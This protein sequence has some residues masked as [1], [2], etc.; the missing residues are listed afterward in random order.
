[1]PS[2]MLADIKE[3]LRPESAP[4]R[5]IPSLDGGLTPNDALE[6]FASVVSL[7]DSEDVVADSGTAVLVTA[8]RALWRVDVRSGSLE[9][10]ASFTGKAMGLARRGDDVLVCVAGLGLVK[11]TGSGEVVPVATAP[12]TPSHRNLTSVTTLGEDIYVTRGS[13]EHTAE[14]WPRDLMT[15]GATGAL[16]RVEPGGGLTTVADGIAWAYGACALED[17]IAVTESWAHRVL[18]YAPSTGKTRVLR[19]RLPG[20]PA[21][22]HPSSGGGLWLA[23]ISLRT[24]LVEFVLRED[25]FRER[26][27][28]EIP[29][30]DWIRPAVRTTNTV[31]E[32]LQL[33]GVRHLGQTKPWAPARSYGLVAELDVRGEFLRSYHSRPG[34]RRHGTT[35]AVESAEGL[36]VL[37]AGASEVLLQASPSERTDR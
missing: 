31:R 33:G 22:L 17:G 8:G 29:M 5:A 3:F 12:D 13:T 36:T 35:A 2:R 16:L 34:G 14:E 21:R 32:P 23:M 10:L 7:A 1:M 30:E 6:G 26:M 25:A 4:N 18:L 11:V 19:D 27:I 37:S 15:K 28:E 24:Y 9:R 20:Y